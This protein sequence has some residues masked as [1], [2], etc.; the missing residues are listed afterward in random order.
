MVS[1]DAG[2]QR[3]TMRPAHL[4]LL[5]ML[6]EEPGAAT[7]LPGIA[8]LRAAGLVVG[9]LPAREVAELLDAIAH[10]RLRVEVETSAGARVDR[11]TVWLAG[12]MGV[13]AE[14]R[15]GGEYD[16]AAVPPAL[17]PFALARI[18]NL[19]PRPDPARA[20]VVVARRAIDQLSV[21]EA[22]LDG[23]DAGMIAW[24]V[25]E[26]RLSWRMTSVWIDPAGD[27]QVAEL[28]VVDAMEA[29]LWIA[30]LPQDPDYADPELPVTLT[31]CASRDVWNRI[32]G[33]L[34]NPWGQGRS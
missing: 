20:P 16:Y 18:V 2:R 3:V 7:A 24:L 11:H 19:Q 15:P 23:E 26:H 21:G 1:F 17:L 13:S 31:P 9:D 25:R 4:G 27:R 10:A 32:V 22:G 28:T 6:V 8:E 29:G 14:A 33:L 12:G 34:P 30:S 5:G